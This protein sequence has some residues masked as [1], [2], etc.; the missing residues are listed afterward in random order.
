MRPESLT[1][2]PEPEIA[3]A[4]DEPFARASEWAGLIPSTGEVHPSQPTEPMSPLSIYCEL[5]HYRIPDEVH[6]GRVNPRYVREDR[7]MDRSKT[8][9]FHSPKDAR[10][11]HTLEVGTDTVL[12]R[13]GG[14]S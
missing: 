9:K 3:Q 5:T 13:K 7:I 6:V 11:R 8:Q 4:R 12:P 14:A 2:R 1:Q 10:Q